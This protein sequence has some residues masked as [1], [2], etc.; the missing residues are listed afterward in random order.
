[1]AAAKPKKLP[2]RR[3]VAE[4]LGLSPENVRNDAGINNLALWDSLGHLRVLLQL[5]EKLGRQLTA[6]E[7]ITIET[8]TDVDAILES[9]SDRSPA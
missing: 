9:V 8:V 6:Q 7:A 3:V 4:A 2:G 5:E 1:M